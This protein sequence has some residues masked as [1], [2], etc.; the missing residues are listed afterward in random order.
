[1]LPLTPFIL[2]VGLMDS[3]YAQPPFIASNVGFSA[4]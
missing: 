1:M 3:P 2:V 4:T